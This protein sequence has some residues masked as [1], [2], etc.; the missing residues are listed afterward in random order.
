MKHELHRLTVGD[1]LARWPFAE[2]HL[3][4]AGHAGK[5]G[6][7]IGLREDAEEVAFILWQLGVAE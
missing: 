4:D 3:M 6:R 2:Q 1:L 7:Y 5:T